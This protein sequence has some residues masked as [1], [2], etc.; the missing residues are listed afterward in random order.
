VVAKGVARFLSGGRSVSDDWTARLPEENNELFEGVVRRWEASYAMLSIVLNE[1]FSLRARG[2]L[3]RARQQLAVASDLSQLLA[4]PLAGAL[5][6]MGSHARQHRTYS[7]VEPLNPGF[8]RGGTGHRAAS[9][10]SLLHS[11][12]LGDRSRFLQKIHAL[13]K[14]VKELGDEFSCTAATLVEGT[15]TEPGVGWSKLDVL[16]FDLNTCVRETVVVLK[17][18]LCVIPPG[19]LGTLRNDLMGPPTS[20][21]T[22]ARRTA[23]VAT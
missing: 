22:P 14:A 23:R 2:E 18:F 3:V 6:A 8:F 5:L 19:D 9:W 13:S 17:S 10:S 16:H 21:S 20:R 15:S 1:A 11:V 4:I 7:R 12:L